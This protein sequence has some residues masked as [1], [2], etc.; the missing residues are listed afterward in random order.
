[1]SNVNGEVDWAALYVQRKRQL[2]RVGT[3]RLSPQDVLPDLL[4]ISD[5]GLSVRCT[6]PSVG[7]PFGIS[8]PASLPHHL[9][10]RLTL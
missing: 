3:I 2:D 7:E 1:M 8:S 9:Y 10:A 5:D 4:E 6:G